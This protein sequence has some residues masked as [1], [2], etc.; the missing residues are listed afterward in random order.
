M[1]KVFVS[2]NLTRDVDFYQGQNTDVARCGIAVKRP[3]S[4]DKEVDFFNVVAF[5]KTAEFMNKYFAKGSRIIIEGHLRF[6]SYKDKEGV[7]RNAVDV[8]VDNVE[9]AGSKNKSEPARSDTPF[10][11]DSVPDEDTPF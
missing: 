4:K 2:G 5:G 3:Y 7:K 9:F 11:G 6:S 8:I 1:N 10:D